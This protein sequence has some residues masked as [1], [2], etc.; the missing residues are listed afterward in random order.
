VTGPQ[1]LGRTLINCLAQLSRA[2]LLGVVATG[3]SKAP[4]T[5][6]AVESTRIARGMERVAANQRVADEVERVSSRAREANRRAEQKQAE[7]APLQ[8]GAAVNG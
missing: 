7:D 4:V 8:R 6:D 1:P 3:C 5:D 2:F